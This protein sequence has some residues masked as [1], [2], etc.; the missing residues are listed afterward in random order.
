MAI[1]HV[2]RLVFVAREWTRVPPFSHGH[3]LDPSDG[4]EAPCFE[5]WSDR[6]LDP[7]KCAAAVLVSPDVDVLW[8]T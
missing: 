2:Q 8:I 4:V 5:I 1:R 7:S 3:L 6:F